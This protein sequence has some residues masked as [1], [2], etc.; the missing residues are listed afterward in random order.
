MHELSSLDAVATAGLVASKEISTREVIEAAIERIEQTNP[1]L[2][3][4]I[5]PLFDSA[6]RAAE[7][8]GKGPLHGVPFLMKDALCHTRGDPY[9]FG[10]RALREAG[11]T[12]K[13][14]TW[15]AKR[16]RAAG[17]VLCGKTNTPELAASSVT[18]PVAYGPT[19]NPWDTTRTAAG[20]S[21][22]SAAAVASGMVPVAHGNDMAGSVRIPASACGLV[23]LKPSRARTSL[24]PDYGEFSWQLTTEFVLTRSV[25]DAAAVLDAIS[26]SA[27]GDPYSAAPPQRVYAAEIGVDPGKLTIGFE[28]TVPGSDTAADA[29]CVRAVQESV[30][31]LEGLGH[32]VTHAA[33]AALRE[34]IID[35]L[36]DIWAVT[37]A[38]ELDRWSHHLGRDLEASNVEE[39][40][41]SQAERGRALPGT[42]WLETTEEL[43]RYGRNVASW[44]ESHDLLVT[45]TMPAPTPKLDADGFVADDEKPTMEFTVPFNVTG[46]P[47]ISVPLGST[48]AGLPVGVQIAA[49][50]REDLLFRV[51]SQLE[52]A[53][54]WQ[55]VAPS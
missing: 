25:R 19:R 9:H 53:A 2:N 51:A 32:R 22:G 3:A 26:G 33:P 13:F 48:A 27:P 49:A 16:F 39:A 28:T 52:E 30:A 54:A 35:P 36:L 15:L 14:D 40:T 21:G 20:S 41:W 12:A 23:G 7:G 29:D 18:C 10:M 50:G 43:H 5:T 6:R 8:L 37:M 17:L 47:A 44:W 55:A 24:G 4:V 1:A 34:P 45:P 11:W 31:L 46:Q 42:R 38:T